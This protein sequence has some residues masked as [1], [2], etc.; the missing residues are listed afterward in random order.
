M[1]AVDTN[2]LVRLLLD[3]DE[4]QARA[5]RSLQRGHAPLFVSH[6]VLAEAAWVL[7][8]A[9]RFRRDRLRALI[10]MLLYKCDATDSAGPG[11]PDR[12][13]PRVASQNQRTCSLRSRA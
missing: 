3:H 1:S 10:Q 9:Y 4:E 7:S 12:A 13:A 6:V 2:V 11:T 5:A 8:S